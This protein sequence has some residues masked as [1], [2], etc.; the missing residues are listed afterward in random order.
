M[1]WWHSW[2]PLN[3][4]AFVSTYGVATAWGV[5]RYCP[6]HFATTEPFLLAYLVRLVD[7]ERAAVG[8]MLRNTQRI[9]LAFVIILLLLIVWDW[10]KVYDDEK[11]QLEKIDEYRGR[12]RDLEDD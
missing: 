1:A 11:A 5:L 6:E 12:L 3:L 8:T 4:L 10:V 9:S 2:R 7:R